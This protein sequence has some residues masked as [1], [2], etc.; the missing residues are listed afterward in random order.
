VPTVSLSPKEVGLA[1]LAALVFLDESLAE[2]STAE[3]LLARL[4]SQV[5]PPPPVEGARPR[6][7]MREMSGDE[8]H[9]PPLIEA[10]RERRRVSFRYRSGETPADQTRRV[11]PWGVGYRNGAW[12]LASF[13]IDRRDSR[14]F[15]VGRIA[16]EVRLTRRRGAFPVPADLELGR[17][18]D[19]RPWSFGPIRGP[20]AEA[21]L[22]VEATHADALSGAVADYISVSRLDD[23]GALVR[24]FVHDAGALF[25][26][27]LPLLPNVELL[28]P[29]ELRSQLAVRLETTAI[30]WTRS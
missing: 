5:A 13:D 23:G 7:A 1:R 10:I 8:G 9:L 30:A 2:A 22:L 24:V 6:W 21:R 16:G 20:A 12:Y 3:R 28:G 11:E 25:D 4:A 29:E 18:F 17:L 27:I 19:S 14:V 26:W 15:R